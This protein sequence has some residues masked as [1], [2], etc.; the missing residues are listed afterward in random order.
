MANAN[1]VCVPSTPQTPEIDL[2]S[3]VLSSIEAQVGNLNTLFADVQHLLSDIRD[4]QAQIRDLDRPERPS[5]QG[6]ATARAQA[7]Q[8]YQAE[9]TRF[10]QS[11]RRL[12]NRVG[13]FNQRLQNT[14]RKIGQAKALLNRLQNHDL[15]AAER[16]QAEALKRA[17][18]NAQQTL[19]NSRGTLED[20]PDQ[21]DDRIE[22]RTVDK[23]VELMLDSDPEF[24]DVVRAFALLVEL[25]QPKREPELVRMPHTP[26]AGLPPVHMA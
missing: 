7:M 25:G 9:L 24:K 2:T 3:G 26:A 14:Y 4:V 11:L 13:S 16:K 8:S 15:P 12:Q 23:K 22:V 18:E 17:L 5:V 21:R 6:D 20:E 1:S 10:Q 19:D